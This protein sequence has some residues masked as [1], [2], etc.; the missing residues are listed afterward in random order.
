MYHLIKNLKKGKLGN[1]AKEVQPKLY[2]RSAD[3]ENNPETFLK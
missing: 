3:T 2:Q 1:P